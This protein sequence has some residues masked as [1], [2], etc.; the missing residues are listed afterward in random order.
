M[1]QEKLD[2][3]FKEARLDLVESIKSKNMLEEIKSYSDENGKL[4]ME[5]LA[6]FSLTES[7][8]IS[9]EYIEKVLSKVLVEENK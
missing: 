6:I 5:D 4:G 2:A 8:N 9:M 1:N 7:M 3:I